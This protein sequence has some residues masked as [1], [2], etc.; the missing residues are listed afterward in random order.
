MRASSARLFARISEARQTLTEPDSRQ[1]YDAKLGQGV[2]HDDEENEQKRIHEI[3]NAATSFQKAEVLLKKRMLAAAEKEARSAHE[4]DPGQ[5]DY[6]ALLAWINASKTESSALLPE[7]LGQLNMAVS[8]SPESE[9]IRFYRAQ[10]LSRLG[11]KQE[12]L[13]DYK[14]VVTKN[15]RNIDAQRE[16]RL[17]EMRKSQVSSPA[18][19]TG[20]A[21]RQ[22]IAPQ[23]KGGV[24][25]KF[26]KR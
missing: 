17:S 10:V 24:F 13:A 3:I 4:S 9:K 23:S 11:R 2:A 22:S 25:S 5:A 6:L 21:P 12:A 19:T 8:M 20:S 1:Q 16:L 7:S 18:L 14:F 15:P 26:F